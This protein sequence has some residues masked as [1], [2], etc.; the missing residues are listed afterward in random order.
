MK[1]LITGLAIFIVLIISVLF[2][3]DY[4]RIERTEL[5][6][7]NEIDEAAAGAV[8]MFDAEE[9]GD[10]NIVIGD[11]EAMEYV[12][13]ITDDKYDYVMHIFDDSLIYR[14]HGSNG[15]TTQA[16]ITLPYSFTDGAG[17]TTEIEGPAII[18][19][20]K[21]DGQFYTISSLKGI[22]TDIKRSSMYVIEGR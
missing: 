10:G 1:T 7:K 15:E 22:K 5:T 9:Y 17:Y 8:F 14:Q 13:H 21:I 16:S 12:Q 3:T 6:L 20:A 2:Q 19:E 18:V 11:A 4:S